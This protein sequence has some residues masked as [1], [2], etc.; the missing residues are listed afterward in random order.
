MNYLTI[1][2]LVIIIALCLYLAS[3]FLF[4]KYLIDKPKPLN[5]IYKVGVDNIEQPDSIRYYYEMWLWV[6]G[7]FPVDKVNTIFGR[8]NK[9]VVGLKGS[10]LS[11]YYGS[12][13]YDSSSGV[14]TPDANTKTMSIAKNFPFQKW[15]HFTL[16]VDSGTVDAYL[17]GKLVSSVQPDAN[18]VNMSTYIPYGDSSGTNINVGNK[19]TQGKVTRFRRPTG[20]INPQEVWSHFTIGNGEGMSLTPYHVNLQVLKDNVK[21]SDSR[22]F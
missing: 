6:D 13:A 17:D 2:I 21:Q 16:N 10:N 20:N 18:S 22:V 8:G 7:N 11:L 3:Y 12:G 5:E 4:P 19:Y 15:T 14:F 1:G 9:F